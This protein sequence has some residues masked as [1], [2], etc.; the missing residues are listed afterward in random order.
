MNLWTYPSTSHYHLLILYEHTVTQMSKILCCCCS[1]HLFQVSGPPAW[2]TNS[3][4][5]WWISS[6]VHNMLH[7]AYNI[8]DLPFNAEK[9]THKL[10]KIKMINNTH[11]F[12][13]SFNCGGLKPLLDMINNALHE[14]TSNYWIQP[15]SMIFK[16]AYCGVTA[17]TWEEIANYVN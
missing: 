14:K 10:Q 6:Q 9:H 16:T 5:S 8:K 3:V 11:H 1:W 7:W 12:V 4:R 2:L 17:T 13:L 15:V